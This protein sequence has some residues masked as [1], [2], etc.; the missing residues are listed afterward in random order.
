MALISLFAGAIGW[1]IRRQEVAAVFDPNTGLAEP[2]API[3]TVLIVVSLVTVALL[4]GLSFTVSKERSLTT[5]RDAFGGS[6]FG[7]ASFTVLGLAVAALAALEMVWLFQ[8]ADGPGGL[9]TVRLLAALLAGLCLLLTAL[10][11]TRGSN[12]AIPAAAPVFWLCA[13]LVVKHIDRA[14]DPVILS[15]AYHLFA[16]AALLLALYYV[17]G[18]AFGK[19]QPRRLMFCSSVAVYFTG[20]TMGDDLSF[21]IRGTLLA[22]AATVLIY[23]LVLTGNLARGG[24]AEASRTGGNMD[25]RHEEI[26]E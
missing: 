26:N 8:T 6:V 15:Y 13:W 21:P 17:A 22:L 24:F 20:V 11:G 1:L 4:F 19:H 10:L 16:L 7:T 2:G 23:Q 25:E 14:A 18:Y 5:F 3:T 9:A 12:V